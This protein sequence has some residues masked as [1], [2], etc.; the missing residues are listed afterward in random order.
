MTSPTAATAPTKVAFPARCQ[1]TLAYDKHLVSQVVPAGIP[2]EEFFEG[3]V[4]LLDEDLKR[5]GSDGVSLPPGSYEL[6]KVNGVRL[7]IARSLD[8]LGVQ[9]GD[10]LVLVPAAAGDSF[11]PQYESLSSALAAV[12]R[13]L[14]KQPEIVCPNPACRHQFDEQ[15]VA[16]LLKVKV[17]RMFTPVTAL[18][19]AHT[20]IAILAMAVA[21]VVALTLRARTFTD[22]WAPAALAGGVGALLVV[23]TAV[24][25]SMWPARRDLISGF[26][27]LAV[28]AVA[29]AAACAPPGALAAAHALIG[30]VIVALG[31]IAI[32][33][34]TRSQTAVAAGL[35]T[36]C[37]IAAGV[38]AARMWWSV[39]PQVIGICL[40]FA[41]LLLVRLTPTVALWVARVRPPYFGS[42]TGR[43]LFARREGLPVDTVSP[44]SEDEDEDD[45]LI[46]TSARGE[47]IAA[48]ARLV[49]AVQVGMCAAVSAVLPVAVWLV[50]TPGQPRQW[51]ALILAALVAGIFITQGRGFAAR[52]QAIALVCGSCTAVFAGIVKY[53]LDA[54]GDSAAGL[55]WPVAAAVIF[56]GLGLAAGLLVPVTRFIPFIRLAVEWL[57]VL[58]LVAVLPLAAWLG[59]LF[60][61]VRN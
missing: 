53:A 43:D 2:V 50:L 23:G 61:W 45:E 42:I 19:A 44:V 17:D 30:V 35:V 4:E 33:V 20:A 31:A 13:R 25:W 40:L 60:A 12:G 37:S 55:L 8:E 58:A 1:V 57:E 6:Q 49:N 5:R 7:D 26:G 9:D 51:A 56:A 38:A 34:I 3:M 15:T 10:T 41:L 27:W 21:V 14:G 11:E 24:V 59:G 22:H 29:V 28:A 39:T 54:P 18:T 16:N 36:V 52:W 46:D 47:A 32:S 48:S